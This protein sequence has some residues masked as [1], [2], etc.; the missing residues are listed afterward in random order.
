MKR[1]EEKT[2]DVMEE[3]TTSTSEERERRLTRNSAQAPCVQRTACQRSK[4]TQE[5]MNHDHLVRQQRARAHRRTRKR[6][7]ADGRAKLPRAQHEGRLTKARETLFR[8]AQLGRI[9]P[10]PR[11]DILVRIEEYERYTHEIPDGIWKPAGPSSMNLCLASKTR[12]QGHRHRQAQ[13]GTQAH[14]HA[15]FQHHLEPT[16]AL[17]PFRHRTLRQIHSHKKLSGVGSL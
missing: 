11:P 17:L 14:R 1:A 9:D 6:E 5:H 8:A 2:G 12:R 15:G 4:N 3:A 7:P 10:Q 16:K 13:A